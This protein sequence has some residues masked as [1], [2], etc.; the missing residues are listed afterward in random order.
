M[1]GG[2]DESLVQPEW[3]RHGQLYV[4]SDR[5]DWWNVYRVDG[6][7]H[8]ALPVTF[9]RAEIGQPAWVFGQSRY[10]FT[11]DGTVV[12]TY[13]EGRRGA[14]AARLGRRAR[15]AHQ[16]AALHVVGIGAG[17][18]GRRRPGGGDLRGRV[19]PPRAGRRPGRAARR[20]RRP[21]TAPDLRPEVLH[22]PRDLGLPP[23]LDRP[24]RAHHVPHRPS[25]GGGARLP[26]PADQ[27]G[28]HGARRRAAPAAGALPRRARPRR[29]TRPTPS[30][31][32]SGP[33]GASPWSTST[34]AA[35]PATAAPTG[36]ASTAAG[37]SSTWRTAWRPPPGWSS[38]AWP[39]PTGWR[40]GAARPAG[41]PR[42][43]R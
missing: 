33:A 2:A 12:C 11:A 28:L 8:A 22:R 16:A 14:A 13:T 23:D 18:P 42:S 36:G 26:L 39:T 32:S 29:P 27:P 3:G 5:D 10:G 15:G 1:A 24:G 31:C 35:P 41:S 19:R 38:G 20:G 17:Q 21:A 7:R 30:A 40:S 4:V 9:V 6:S 37:A 34:T 43:P 25:G